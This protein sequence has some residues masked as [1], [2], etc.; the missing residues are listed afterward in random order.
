MD[1]ATAPQD[2]NDGLEP[3]AIRPRA[4]QI[5]ALDALRDTLAR[6]DR[7]QA[8][9]CCGSGK[10]YTQAFLAQHI[11]D[12]AEDPGSAVI[13]CFVPNRA[14]IH[15]NARNFHKVLG[16]T[17]DTL[18]V[19]SDMDLTGIVAD[20][21]LVE[22]METTTDPA[23]ITAFLTATHKPRVVYST[24]HSAPTL[25]AS[26]AEA[27]GEGT[28]LALGLFDEAHR[29]AGDKSADSLFA[30]GLDDARFPMVKR[31]FFTAT[32]RISEGKTSQALSMSDPDL[33]GPIATEYPFSQGIADGNVVDTDLWV[34]IITRKEL[35]AYMAGH[36]METEERAAVA[37]IALEKVMARTG[38]SRFLSYHRRI[39]NSQS[40]AR[41]LSANPAFT[42]TLVAHVDGTTPGPERERLMQA[43]ASGRTILTNCK[44]FVE[45]VDAP[46][47][48]GAIFVDSRKS[49]VDVVQ[50]VGRLSRPDPND[51][52]K[53]GSVIAPILAES[54][55][56]SA[57]AR[58]AKIA[59]FETLIQ[60]IEALRANDDA[61]AEDI[62]ER[63]RAMGRGDAEV[64]T[65]HNLEILAPDDADIDVEE[66]ALAIT[67]ATMEELR[68]GFAEMVGKLERHMADHGYM[69]TKESDQRLHSWVQTTRKKHAD[70]RLE[71]VHAA[72]L[73]S[74]EGWSWVGERARPDTIAA[75]I[76]AFRDRAQRMPSGKRGGQAEAD[77]HAYL[78]EAQEEYLRYGTGRG[79]KLTQTLQEANLLFFTDEVLGKRAHQSGH[80]TFHKGT[81]GAP[82]TVFFHPRP[83]P[84]RT[85]VPVFRSGHTV[86]PRRVQLHVGRGERERLQ[87]LGPQHSLRVTL[88]RAGVDTD[89]F[90]D[91]RILEWHAGTADRG[92]KPDTSKRSLTWLLHRLLDRK[93]SGRT[94][95][96]HGAVR[97]KTIRL[98]KPAT[99]LHPDAPTGTIGEV[100]DLM[101]RAREAAAAGRLDPVRCKAL[102]E[103]PG[104]AW[105]EAD[106]L[107]EDAQ[108]ALGPRSDGTPPTA[109]DCKPL[110]TAKVAPFMEGLRARWGAAAVVPRE[111]R[112]KDSGLA[113]TLRA[114]DALVAEG[115]VDAS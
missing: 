109:A 3:A 27:R 26:L 115:Y 93:V 94:P 21:D 58:A 38:Q 91:G 63:S 104:F 24:Y 56:P 103:V 97:D 76:T 64:T 30:F 80:V 20:E 53:R 65:L 5:A 59:G 110:V 42:G 68:D 33:Y 87:A 19:C 15:Q 99:V 74:V 14:L 111:S 89:P 84:H 50:A 55:E 29:T 28:A 34:P 72:L 70:G 41:A 67:V 112:L 2:S 75:H 17:V 47:L 113:N 45:G 102:D 77:L 79:S 37:M 11:L 81:G 7:A 92:E 32:P 107:V 69:P 106:T 49:V 98:H 16:D 96:T 46:G 66:L 85:T 62:L 48:Q 44:A 86:P 36:E 88:V 22:G 18:G 6:G 51:P 31:A 108:R 35:A 101:E 73:D 83:D 4:H 9:M 25:R 43:L 10:T 105:F 57:I 8:H 95:Y 60:V 78:M 82:D 54:T 12:E 39:A 90:Q 40:F 71:S 1:T 100:M 52:G 13:V 61:L 114:W 23:T